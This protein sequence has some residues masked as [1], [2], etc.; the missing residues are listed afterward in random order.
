MRRVR[1][2]CVVMAAGNAA[3]FGENKLAAQLDGKPLIWHALTAVPT[4][5]FEEVA[6]VTQYKEVKEMAE[7]FGFTAIINACPERGVSHTIALGLQ[8]MARLDA[9]LFQ[10]ADQPLLRRKTVAGLVAF[11]RR[12]PD[13]IAALGYGGVR[14]NPCLFPAAY[15]PELLALQGDHGGNTVIRQHEDCLL[16]WEAPERELTDV[17]TPE[18]LQELKNSI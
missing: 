6:V 7:A 16:I 12:H 13:D 8:A 15:F 17:D 14:G 2:G 3:R 4:E 5:C 9:V 18:A 11:Y 10:V 1:I